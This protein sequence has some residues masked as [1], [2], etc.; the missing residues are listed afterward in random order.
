MWIFWFLAPSPRQRCRIRTNPWF[1][2]VEPDTFVTNNGT[3]AERNNNSS[4]KQ[5]RDRNSTGSTTSSSGIKTNSDESNEKIERPNERIS[6]GLITDSDSSSSTEKPSR[7]FATL[8]ELKKK[9]NNNKKEASQ[10]PI[11]ISTTQH[12]ETDDDATL[13]EIGKFDESYVYEKENDIIR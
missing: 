11:S 5:K 7:T 8:T 4:N 3:N 13:N 12:G 6:S 10:L 9:C 2:S 1:S